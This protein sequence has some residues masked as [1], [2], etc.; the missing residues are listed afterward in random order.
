MGG[1]KAC[2]SRPSETSQHTFLQAGESDFPSISL[3]ISLQIWSQ[4]VPAL[5]PPLTFP[6]GPGPCWVS[7]SP[8]APG[9]PAKA[10]LSPAAGADVG[11]GPRVACGRFPPSPQGGRTEGNRHQGPRGLRRLAPCLP[12]PAPTFSGPRCD[13]GMCPELSEPRCAPLWDG[14]RPCSGGVSWI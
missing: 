6:P 5:F 13:P 4:G 14:D 7:S 10:A 1:G 2:S 9:A 11:A 8:H 12:R 3:S